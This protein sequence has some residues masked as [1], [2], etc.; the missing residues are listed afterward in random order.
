MIAG[1]LLHTRIWFAAVRIELR[2]ATQYR[3][4][5]AI[6]IATSLLTIVVLFYFW[7]AVFEARTDV[8]GLDFR[9]MFRYIILSQLVLAVTRVS[10]VA[11]RLSDGIRDGSLV[12]HLPKPYGLLGYML[13]TA[14]AG[15]AWRALWIG[16]PLMILGAALRLV[17]EPAAALALFV[18]SLLLALLTNTAIELSLGLAAVWLRRNEGL[19]HLHGFLGA[20]LS[21]AMFPLVL[22]PEPV[23]RAVAVLPFRTTSDIPI[24]YYLGFST[25]PAILLQ[26]GWCAA[27]WLLC[28]LLLRAAERRYVGFG[29]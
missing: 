25:R 9:F 20:F 27:A 14:M 2:A 10:G 17:P 1:L 23:R 13:A 29:G 24:G 22:L 15:V 7:R 8:Q 19:I 3:A 21:G 26:I 6:Q 28:L 5:L 18:P 4:N 11:Y 16:V 12:V